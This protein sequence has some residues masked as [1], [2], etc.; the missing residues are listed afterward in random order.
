MIFLQDRRLPCVRC[1]ELVRCALCNDPCHPLRL[2]M[3]PG[4]H[5][6]EGDDALTLAV[7]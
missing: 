2:H 7:L 5:V 3:I 1:E 6:G 4:T